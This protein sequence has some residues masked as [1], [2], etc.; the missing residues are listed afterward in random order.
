MTR[1]GLKSDTTQYKGR[2]SKME[3]NYNDELLKYESTVKAPEHEGSKSLTTIT[4][5][6]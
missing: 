6:T 4:K 2:T 3:N 5:H 1:L